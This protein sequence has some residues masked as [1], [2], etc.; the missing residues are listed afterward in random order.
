MDETSPDE[1]RRGYRFTKEMSEETGLPVVMVALEARLIEGLGIG[2]GVRAE[3][4]DCPIL[5]VYRFML[6]PWRRPEN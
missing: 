2:S 4:F 6:P 5:P 1:V 3:E